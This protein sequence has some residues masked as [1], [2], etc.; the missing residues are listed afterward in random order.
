MICQ[1]SAATLRCCP[2]LPAPLQ[3]TG[4]IRGQAVGPS[5]GSR[6]GEKVDTL[7]LPQLLQQA[8]PHPDSS[9]NSE[10]GSTSSPCGSCP[11][12]QRYTRCAPPPIVHPACMPS[13]DD[14]RGARGAHTF[15]RRAQS[16]GISKS[17]RKRA[18]FR[19]TKC[20]SLTTSLPAT[21]K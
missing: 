18:A 15:A 3:W 19:A 13:D 9:K 10:D 6:G 7:P 12:T 16:S 5:R 2:A 1:I 20:C 21:S 14:G 17:C 8:L 11:T 4:G